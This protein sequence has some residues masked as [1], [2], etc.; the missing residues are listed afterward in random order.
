MQAREDE[1]ARGPPVFTRSKQVLLQVSARLVGLGDQL[2]EPLRLLHSERT[3]DV[4]PQQI[5][6]DIA[7]RDLAGAEPVHT[8][9]GDATLVV[10]EG[11]ASLPEE[12]VRVRDIAPGS[13]TAG[14]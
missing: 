2:Q 3:P 9:V 7:Q 10:A 5:G 8:L 4:E 14:C 12:R 6:P 1:V 13:F 11:I